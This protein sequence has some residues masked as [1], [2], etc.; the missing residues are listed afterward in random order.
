MSATDLAWLFDLEEIEPDL[1]RSVVEPADTPRHNLYGGL[2]CAWALMAGARTVTSDRSAHS[3]HGYF[4]RRGRA[5][6]PVI[7]KVDR[8]RDG[9]SFSARHVIAVQDGEVILS[10]LASFH[11]EEDGA[12]YETPIRMADVPDPESLEPNPNRRL[13]FAALDVR[14]I[15]T[16]QD[17]W[18]PPTRQWVKTVDPLPDDPIIHACVIAYISDLGSG[19]GELEVEGLPKGGPTIDHAFWFNGHHRADEWLYLDQWPIKAIASRGLYMG[20]MHTR[21][22]KLVGSLTQEALLRPGMGPPPG[23]KPEDGFPP[24]RS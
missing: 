22:G 7:L 13:G 15:V 12:T 3:L 9:R 14:N 4:L 18:H 8:D 23:W 20:A 5:D 1:Y 21:D 2:V 17:G 11:A 10:M 16:E 19:F 24:P 6:R